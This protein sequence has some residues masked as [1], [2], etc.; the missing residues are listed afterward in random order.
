MTRI[1]REEFLRLTRQNNVKIGLTLAAYDIST[2]FDFE[3]FDRL[4]RYF[5]SAQEIDEVSEEQPSKLGYFLMPAEDLDEDSISRF[6]LTGIVKLFV[7]NPHDEFFRKLPRILMGELNSPGEFSP[8]ALLEAQGLSGF[9]W[10]VLA[11]GNELD[12]PFFL[13][14]T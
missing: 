4:H 6:L 2:K 5:V 1:D 7:G 13:V 12:T 3:I 14:S 10:L 8:A 11:D 9:D